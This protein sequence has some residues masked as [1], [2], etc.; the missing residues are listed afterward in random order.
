VRLNPRPHST[1]CQRRASE[2]DGSDD[3]ADLTLTNV[4]HERSKSESIGSKMWC[5]LRDVRFSKNAV[6]LLSGHGVAA[7]LLLWR[8]GRLFFVSSETIARAF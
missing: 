7:L 3:V 2:Y 5:D 1:S 4:Q 8:Q 6:L